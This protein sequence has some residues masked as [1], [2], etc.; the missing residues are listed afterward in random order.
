MTQQEYKFNPNE[1]ISRLKGKDYLEVKWRLVWFRD[2]YPHGE[3]RTSIAHID[4]EKGIAVFKAEISDG[5][6][7]HSEGHGSETA[8]D[9]GDYLEKAETKAIGR[10]LAALGYG[11]QFAPE[12]EEG[13]HVVDSPVNKPQTTQQ[14]SKPKPASLVDRRRLVYD[15]ALELGQFQKGATKEENLKAFLAF[16]K[17]II[18]ANVAS[19][20]QL[21]NSRLDAIEAYLDAK[22]VA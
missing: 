10:A 8:K 1:H 20:E 22:D 16:V 19:I 4:T 7:G 21:T 11:T 18:G 13:E 3:I 5:E 14:D 15:R 17:P 2:Q 12:M 9:F 6:G